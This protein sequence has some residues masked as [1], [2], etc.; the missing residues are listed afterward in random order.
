MKNY[1]KL[2]IIPCAL[3]LAFILLFVFVKTVDVSV[4]GEN[5]TNIG[6]T[7]MN[8]PFYESHKTLNGTFYKL[9]KYLGYL[10]FL[11]IAFFA[12][13]GLI[14]FIKR[15]KFLEVDKDILILG[16]VYIFTLAL[17]FFFDFVPVNVR[18]IIVE[19]PMEASFPS[20]HTLMGVVVFGTAIYEILKRFTNKY[21]K[22]VLTTVSGILMLLMIA[23]RT[24]SGVHWIS[25]IVS[26]IVLGLFI[27]SLFIT[28]DLNITR[29]VEQEE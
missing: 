10:S 22:Y 9:S 11:M 6:L 25:D 7:F 1:K 20:S 3:L 16:I 15:K 21:L 23:F 12:G 28:L 17:Y 8:K 13:I 14:Q 4:L 19:D 27:V 29:N 24:L 5:S 26:G 2:F 18:P